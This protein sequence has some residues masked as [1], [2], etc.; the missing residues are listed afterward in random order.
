MIKKALKAMKSLRLNG[1]I[2]ILE[3]D[4]SNC[5]VVLDESKYKNKFNTLL[6]SGV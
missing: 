5:T 2:R 6:G 3:A 4:K 1:D